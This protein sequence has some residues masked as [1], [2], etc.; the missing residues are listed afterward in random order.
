MADAPKAARDKIFKRLQQQ[1]DNRSCFDCNAKS[2]TWTSI[3]FGIFLCLNCSSTHRNLGVH[4]SFVRSTQLDGWTWDQLRIMQCGGNANC[5]A[6]FRQ[7]GIAN[8]DATAKYGSRPA[9]LYK[10][11]LAAAATALQK[12]LGTELFETAEDEQAEE[13]QPD[14]FDHDQHAAD[15]D[16]GATASI[17]AVSSDGHNDTMDESAWH[18]SADKPEAA[19]PKKVTSLGAKKGGL[20]AKKKGG[21]GA[22]KVNKNFDAVEAKA[23]QQDEQ[24]SKQVAAAAEAG[25]PVEEQLS[26]RL[27]LKEQTVERNIKKMDEAKAAQAERLGMGLGKVVRPAVHS[28]SAAAAM[29]TIQQDQPE[30]TSSSRQ[31]GSRFLDK[32]PGRFDDFSSDSR[33]DGYDDG[34]GKDDF[35]NSFEP[36]T[37]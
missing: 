1:A 24:R 11:K 5:R 12:K 31:G 2:P 22:K 3:P 33:G 8:K 32:E 14:F 20:G 26:A 15:G 13:A 7:H 17:A 9:T 21:L 35:F 10:Q 25:A 36:S 34:F 19:Q 6:F 30:P 28:H 18:L 29:T 4:L 16:N 37:R 27:T 23:K